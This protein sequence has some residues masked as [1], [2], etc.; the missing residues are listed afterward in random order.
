MA[1]SRWGR[2]GGRVRAGAAARER[3]APG[4][5]GEVAAVGAVLRG[6]QHLL[7]HP[8]QRGDAGALR[9]R[10]PGLDGGRRRDGPAASSTGGTRRS[11][12][13]CGRAT[14][15][16]PRTSRRPTRCRATA[17]PRAR[18]RSSCCGRRQ[19]ATRRARR[20]PSGTSAGR[21]TWSTP[22]ARTA[23]TATTSGSP[24]AT[25]TT[26]ATTCGRWRRRRSWR[27][28]T[29]TTCC[30]R[31]RSSVRSSTGR[32]RS[33]TRSGTP[34]S[35][36]RLKLGAWEPGA[37]EGGDDAVGPED[38]GAGGRGRRP[39]GG[40]PPGGD[41]GEVSYCLMTDPMTAPASRLLI[42]LMPPWHQER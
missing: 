6:H 24:T 14:A 8:D 29:R 19:P 1:W 16:S 35:R 21:R 37:I 13:R 32:T 18:P 26:C 30:G 34:A 31:A 28:P 38:P 9:P 27:P 25:A 22:T 40:R 41:G 33:P 2:G 3:L 20:R 5:P 39:A 11:A 23:T 42:M 17:T 15:F 10:E 12:T 7:G 36:E 4:L